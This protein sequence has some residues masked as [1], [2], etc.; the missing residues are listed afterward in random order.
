MVNDIIVS[1][2]NLKNI[3]NSLDVSANTLNEYKTR[4]DL[5]FSFLDNNQLNANTFLNFKR[6]LAERTDLTISTKNKYLISAR[7]FLKEAYKKGHIKVDITQNV[8]GFQQS[9]KHKREGL[10]QSEIDK[11]LQYFNEQK[12]SETIL[13]A[14]AIF[15]LL[16][17]QGLRQ[18]EII[19]L[20]VQDLELANMRLHVQGKGRDDKEP[21]DLH[22]QTAKALK[23][24]C[25]ICKIRDGVL[26]PCCSNRAIGKRLT[27]RG[28]RQF[29]SNVLKE[30]SIDKTV[31]GFRHYFTT[32]LIKEFGNLNKVLRYT[33]HR[34][35]EM[36]QVYDDDMLGKE[37]LPKFY[38]A[39][40]S[41]AM[42]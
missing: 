14:K 34:S 15:S 21:I 31:H 37:D 41:L 33:R 18:I 3:L 30:L 12:E 40:N 11:I 16:I 29:V 27:T 2:Q 32:K 7:V 1:Q 4:L 39:F 22:P 28:L 20:D 23:I 8:K 5:F 13:R 24:Y 10:N 17:F 38:N 35:L 19:R 36:L 26:F 9:K 42:N 25:D 6:Y